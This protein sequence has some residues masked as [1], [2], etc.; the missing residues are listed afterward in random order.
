MN[1]LPLTPHDWQEKDIDNLL[2]WDCT[3][4]VAIQTGGGKSLLAVETIRRA[5]HATR[6]AVLIIAPKSTFNDAWVRTIKRQT[7]AVAQVINSKRDGK[8]A[9]VDLRA[10]KPGW[11]IINHELFQR[12]QWGNLQ[13]EVCVVDEVHKVSNF[14]LWRTKTSGVNRLLNFHAKRRIAMGATPY[15]NNFANLWTIL[16]WLHPDT[17]DSSPRRW[18]FQNCITEP[19]IFAG[20][21]VK[22][23]KE[24]GRVV[25]EMLCYIHHAKREAC[26]EFHPEGF[27]ATEEPETEIRTVELT[28]GMRKVYSDLERSYVA[29]LEDNPL[30]VELPIVLRARLRQLSLGIVTIDGEGNVDYAP[31]CESPKYVELVNILDEL[32]DEPVLG[33][34]HSK[35]FAHVVT[36]RLK[37]MNIAAAEWSGDT[38]MKAR[39]QVEDDFAAGRVRV[40][41]GVIAAMGTGVSSLARVTSTCVWLSR[42]D[43]PSD[44]L[45]ASGRLDRLDSI[46]R[47]SNIEI[48][49]EGTYDAGVLSKNVLHVLEMNATLRAS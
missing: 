47:V 28:P 4:L 5:G 36:E 18:I 21:V 1:D 14:R 26:C 24:P 11:F 48:Q 33:L 20:M 16:K 44:N 27:L 12:R 46:G 13:V 43:D 30:V 2:F 7:G 38:S 37:A 3:G 25:S 35:K 23:E 6:G 49:S 41:V 40:I 10:N 32:G 9:E 42:S 19:D 15:R 39:V 45:Q 31:D 17:T 34:T 22:G 8:A 29:F